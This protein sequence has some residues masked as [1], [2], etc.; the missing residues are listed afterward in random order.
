[1]SRG[2][3]IY[4]L[5]VV[6]AGPAGAHLASRAAKAGC[7][8]LLLDHK[9]PWEKPCGGGITHKAWSRYAILNHPDLPRHGV[10]CSLQLSPSNNFFVVDQGHPLYTV[11]RIDLSRVMLEQSIR[12]GAQHIPSAVDRVELWDSRVRLFTDNGRYAADFV[13]GADGVH[14]TVR[15]SF[16]GPLSKDR[17][18][19]S[20]TRLYEGGP[21]DPTMIKVTP[22]PGY[23]WS[24]ARA[25]SLSV[26]V[27]TFERGRDV[28]G[29]LAGFVREFFPGR[30]PLGPA[31]GALLPYMSSIGSYTEKRTG[32]SWA[33]VGDAAGFC[34][35][36][37]GEGIVYAMW[38]ADLFAD[39]FLKGMPG[40]YE[41]AWRK[42]FGMHLITGSLAAKYV[43][44]PARMDLFFSAL[45]ACESFRKPM[46]DYVWELPSY[47]A[48]FGRFLAA[49]PRGYMQWRSFRS[50]GATLKPEQ[51]GPFGHMADM[52]DFEFRP[53]RTASTF[54]NADS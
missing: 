7:K 31:R 25:D 23:C 52:V 1:M 45:T 9:A 12:D 26:G 33:L 48:L 50:S 16:L 6:G 30:K 47:H 38:S 8:V 43:Y 44:T 15:K 21:P 35:T 41:R 40:H 14:S 37:T 20:V 28:K 54:G 29:A 5:A 3:R 19:Y 34:D 36:L 10:M 22:F 42:A 51:L 39:A 32:D 49:F 53:G 24:F 18:I 27:G 2:I 4:D 17:V 13:V 46:M 11:D